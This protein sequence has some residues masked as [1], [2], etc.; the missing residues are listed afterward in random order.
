[1]LDESD[2]MKTVS[3]QVPAK[4]ELRLPYDAQSGLVWQ[5]A[6]GG[7]GFSMTHVPTYSATDRTETFFF[8]MMNPGKLPVVVDYARPGALIGRHHKQFTVYLSGAR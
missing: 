5:L 3:V 7:A 4:V 8:S 2:S 6:S 1:M